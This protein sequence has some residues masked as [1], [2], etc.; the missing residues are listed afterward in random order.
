[1]AR[2]L[3]VGHS[4]DVERDAHHTHGGGGRI[5]MKERVTLLAALSEA[6]SARQT[7]RF[8]RLARAAYTAGASREDLITA[9]EIGRLLGDPV[10]PVPTEAY[11]TVHA[12]Q[13]MASR[14][15]SR[16]EE[17]APCAERRGSERARMWIPCTIQS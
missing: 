8:E 10:E 1:M 14:R 4:L 13:W 11:A 15:M 16:D 7:H 12:W 5:P 9:I 2:R 17:S 6:V 3:L